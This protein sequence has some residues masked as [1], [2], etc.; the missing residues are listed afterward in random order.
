MHLK[1]NKLPA[2]IDY[3]SDYLKKLYG[4]KGVQLIYKN[5]NNPYITQKTERKFQFKY[6]V[7]TFNNLMNNHKKK[8]GSVEP[9]ISPNF[10]FPSIKEYYGDNNNLRREENK[11][12]LDN[13]REDIE[14][15]FS[16]SKLKNIPFYN[17]E[18]LI[19]E[20]NNYKIKNINSN[21]FFEKSK[22]NTNIINN[23]YNLINEEKK[24][25]TLFRNLSNG[26]LF[27]V[28]KKKY[29]ASIRD[30]KKR[31]KMAENTFKEQLEKIKKEKVK[32]SKNEELFKEYEVK[33]NPDKFTESLKN[34]FQFFQDD[35]NKNNLRKKTFEESTLKIKKLFKDLNN[36]D[37]KTSTYYELM[38]NGLKPSQRIIQNILRREKKLETYEKSLIDLAE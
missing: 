30:F 6:V 1:I 36:N 26:S 37:K 17:L 3:N 16:S 11:K 2:R 33:F 7:R 20:K 15:K 34:E 9:K 18:D 12:N 31:N 23:N 10:C 4:E 25:K 21:N 13:K 24:T 14:N 32:K 5:S 22:S 19:N 38:H 28:C 35:D 29:L 27:E 8:Y